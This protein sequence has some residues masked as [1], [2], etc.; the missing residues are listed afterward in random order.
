MVDLDMLNR[1]LGEQDLALSRI[2]RKTSL[3]RRPDDVVEQ[4]SSIDEQAETDN[5]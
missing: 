2:T 5:L 1:L 3:E 4:E